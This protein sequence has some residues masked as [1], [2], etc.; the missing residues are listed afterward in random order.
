MNIEKNGSRVSSSQL[1]V[2]LAKI[3]SSLKFT[4]TNVPR[5]LAYEGLSLAHRS[6]SALNRCNRERLIRMHE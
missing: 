1:K 3:L 6:R 5:E 2:G 4:I